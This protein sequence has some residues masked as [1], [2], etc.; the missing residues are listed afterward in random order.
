MNF[1]MVVSAITAAILALAVLIPGLDALERSLRRLQETKISEA[2][3]QC[4]AIVARQKPR[5]DQVGAEQN[6]CV[7]SLSVGIN[8]NFD[9]AFE[10][11]TALREA[12]LLK[13]ASAASAATSTA[14]GSQ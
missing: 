7:Q 12:L 3:E 11:I 8:Q 2:A 5:P 14:S 10:M 6:K 4:Y 1:T 13:Q 9:V